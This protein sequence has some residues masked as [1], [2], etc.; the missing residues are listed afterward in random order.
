VGAGCVFHEAALVSVFESVDKPRDNHE[1]NVTGTFNVLAAAR[2]ARAQRVIMASTAAIY[3]NRPEVPK[4]EEM[5]PEPESPYGLAKLAGEYYLSI[6]A[7]LYGLETVALRYFNVYGPRQDPRSMYSGVI[8]RFVEAL[9]TGTAPVV[10]GDGEQTR[11]FVYVKDVVA[12]NLL[13]A[14]SSKVGAGQVINIGT[15][16]QTSLLGLLR[17]LKRVSRRRFTTE[18]QPARK[19]DVRHSVAAVGRARALLGYKPAYS[20]EQGLRELW[21]SVAK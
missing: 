6:F 20:L 17:T 7:R 19:G 21:A 16:R 8:S 15:G 12:A 9:R 2:D 4:R 1:I 11:D 3:G 5:L 14:T 13:A 10:C 18:F